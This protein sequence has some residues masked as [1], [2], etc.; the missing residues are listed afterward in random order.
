[1][2]GKDLCIQERGQLRKEAELNLKTRPYAAGTILEC[3]YK[4]LGWMPVKERPDKK[5]PNNRRTYDRTIVNLREDIKLAE[6]YSV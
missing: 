3:D 2:N 4:D 5:H 1:M 6:F